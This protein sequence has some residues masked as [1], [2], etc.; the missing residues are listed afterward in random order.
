[1]EPPWSLPAPGGGVFRMRAV[2]KIG[3]VLFWLAFLILS[4][5]VFL[6]AL[7]SLKITYR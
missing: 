6:L 4:I 7:S 3:V 2:S 5:I 1:M